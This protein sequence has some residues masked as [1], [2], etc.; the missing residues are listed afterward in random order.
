[1]LADLE[2][3]CVLG[4]DFISGS[5]SI[6]DCDRKSLAIPDSQIDT[7]VKTIEEGID[8]SKTRLEEKQKQELRDLFNSFQ[9]LFSDKPV[10]THVLYHEIDTEDKPPVASLSI[11]LRPGKTSNTR[12][13]CRENVERGNHNSDSI[14]LSVTSCVM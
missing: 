2:Y 7:V 5:E 3:S 11:S 9:G 14:P 12:L 13:S 1:M 10:L 6:L 8:L 4:V